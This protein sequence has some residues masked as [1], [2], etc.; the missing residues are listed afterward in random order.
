MSDITQQSP[1]PEPNK[2]GDGEHTRQVKVAAWLA[3]VFAVVA[4]IGLANAPTW[5]V[6]FGIAALAAMVTVVCCSIAKKR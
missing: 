4:A 1:T 6:A 3:G 5:P 2:R